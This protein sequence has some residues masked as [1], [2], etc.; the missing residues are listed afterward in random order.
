M[1]EQCLHVV[2][3]PVELYPASM[4]RETWLRRQLYQSGADLCS[5][6]LGW[7]PTAALP[8]GVGSAAP[9]NPWLGNKVSCIGKGPNEHKIQVTTTSCVSNGRKDTAPWRFR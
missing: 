8:E 6:C 7:E 3:R 1:R 5:V 9:M 2:Q 4:D